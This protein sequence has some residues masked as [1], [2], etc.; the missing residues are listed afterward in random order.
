MLTSQIQPRA[1][2]ESTIEESFKRLDASIDGLA[3]EERENRMVR[4]GENILATKKGPGLI[5]RF[6]KEFTSPFVFLLLGVAGLSLYMGEQKDAI[7]IFAVL[8]LNAIIGTIQSSRANRAL[9][10]LKK[11]E[12][13]Q[14]NCV[15]S[16][17]H[18]ICNV[19]SLVP[20]DIIR[21]TAGDRIPAD[22]RWVR[23][24]ELR[25]DE[26]SLTGES[27]AVSKTS[28]AI[29]VK[30]DAIAADIRNAGYMG[31]IVVA[32]HGHL[33]ITAIGKETEM[34]KIAEHLSDK[35]PEPPLVTRVR[36]L[37]HQVLIAV[38]AIAVLLFI[39][40]IA[41]GQQI[42][43]VVPLILALIVAIVPEGLPVVLTI[44]LAK[45]VKDM[46]AHKA[47]VKELQAVESLGGVDVI[48]TDKTGTITLNELHFRK[49]IL[50]DGTHITKVQDKEGSIRI[51]GDREYALRFASLM[52]SV[53]D[54][55]AHL[56]EHSRSVDPIDCAMLDLARSYQLDIPLQENV[57]P[58]DGVSRTRAVRTSHEEKPITI[59]A[60]SPE[61]VLKACGVTNEHQSSLLEMAQ[62]GLRVIAF[63]ERSGAG[64]E[65][66]EN[67]WK[68]LGMIGLWDEPRK[69]VKESIEWCQNHG[70]R[71]A[72]ITGDH[73]ETAY[74]IAKEVGLADTKSEVVLGEEL[75]ALQPQERSERLKSVRVIARAT[76]ETKMELIRITREE[77]LTVAMTGDGVNDA[78]A[79]HAADIGVAMGATGTDVAREAADLVLLDDRFATIVSA[80]KEG[81][82]VLGNVQK[83]VTYLFATNAMELFVIGAALILQLPSPLLAVQ[84]LWLNFVTDALPVLALAGEPSHG[85]RE[86]PEHGKLLPK[87]GWSRIG[88]L[89]AV[90]GMVGLLS[91]MH[92][93]NTGN[94]SERHSIVLFAMITVQW[95][96]AFSVRS[97]TKSFFMMNPAGN[98]YLIGAIGTIAL[99]TLIS[100]SGGPLSDLLK[101]MSFP[102]KTAIWI[103]CV[104]AITLLPD[105]IWKWQKR[106]QMA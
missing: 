85:G 50:Q 47:I 25:V 29:Q 38:S 7:I 88:L 89:G 59:M 97:S 53:A 44:V 6:L 87:N 57:R 93:L 102:L 82:A 90:M 94:E 77:G 68:Y 76:P 40:A 67:D 9:S 30:P 101:I 86:K 46:S 5:L 105:E 65:Y 63:A 75:M 61:Q 56:E 95:W 43:A 12:S 20:G 35:R 33:L 52:A 26:S 45:G 2:S 23:A 71:V 24:E 106:R 78:P 66:E 64:M 99:I 14:A 58:F 11:E 81:R 22:G 37:S 19:Q 79:L 80:V 96:A 55:D 28:D 51:Q 3:K 42:L 36:T 72:M 69:E 70:I 91:Y 100:F 83:V 103:L 8:V 73:P 32:G 10:A 60:G 34:G 15:I 104:G 49:A 21:V 13:Y 31:T 39:A 18:S 4:F 84:I 48:F 92:A 17:R 54:P 62:Q 16:G 1:L 74:V 41:S 98:K 27:V